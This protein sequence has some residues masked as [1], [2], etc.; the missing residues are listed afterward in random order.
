[1]PPRWCTWFIVLFWL[2]TTGWMFYR[3]AWPHLQGGEPPPYS[4]DLTDEVSV[5][6]VLWKVWYQGKVSGTGRSFVR[7][8][9]DRTYQ[10]ETQFHFERLPIL[11]LE[12]RKMTT[13][14][15]VTEAGELR[16]LGAR[17]VLSEAVIGQGNLELALAVSGPVKQGKFWPQVQVEG[18]NQEVPQLKP[19]DVSGQGNVLNPMHLLNRLSGLRVGQR[20]RIPLVDPLRTILPGQNLGLPFLDAEVKAGDLTWHGE[21]V[22]CHKIEYREP[23]KKVTASTWVRQTDGLVLQQAANHQGL[24]LLLVREPAK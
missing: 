2:A 1:M 20:W 4:I 21:K 18:L 12:L 8:Q 23:G 10:L 22:L 7:R 19:V 16:E 5:Q 13:M 3:E 9:P 24:D 11:L 15:R 17:V 6:P 14:Y